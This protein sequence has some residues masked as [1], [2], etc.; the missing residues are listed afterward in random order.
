MD[1]KHQKAVA[2]VIKRLREQTGY[3]QVELG[4][5]LNI[6]YQQVQKYES[7]KSNLSYAR[8]RQYLSVFHVKIESF[9]RMVEA[10]M[11]GGL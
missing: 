4:E 1:D 11:S 8:L 3:T 6:T 2:K 7:G 5:R 10:E 9:E